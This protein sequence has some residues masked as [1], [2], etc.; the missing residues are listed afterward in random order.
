M[1]DSVTPPASPASKPLWTRRRFLAAAAA[2]AVLLPTGTAAYARYWEP[3]A[4]RVREL[5]MPI[6]DL[7]N[8]LQGKRL[9]QI[10]DIHVGP[11]VD[12]NYL[13]SAFAHL[14]ELRGDLLV[15]TGDFISYS[16]R[17]QPWEK[18]LHLFTNLPEFPLGIYGITGNH[19]CGEDWQQPEIAHKLFDVM[20]ETR[21]AFI[22]NDVLDIEGL[23]LA[24]VCD[25]WTPMY[26][27]RPVFEKLDLTRPK[28]ALCHNPDVIDKKAWADYDGWMLS[29]HTH[30]GQC[31]FPGVGAPILSVKNKRYA[32]GEVISDSGK[33]KLY[34]NPGLG[35]ARP[36]RFL[37][38]P[39][40][41][42]FTLTK[43]DAL[44]A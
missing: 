7:P 26:D 42:I 4:Y 24:G 9:I 17:D 5:S 14:H 22:N 38:P 8:S 20:S 43:D 33:A 32:Q 30:G 2:S 28:L 18:L 36:V 31:W 44:T 41:T 35:Y 1:T 23:Q 10:S 29:G 11:I 21:L 40:I 39:E 3:F 19:D 13:Q 37:V 12:Q 25:L 34:I 16:E 15:V 6:R 27:S